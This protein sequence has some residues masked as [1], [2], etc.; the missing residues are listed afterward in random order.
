MEYTVAQI[1]PVKTQVNV[2]VPAEEATAALSTA[3]ALFR[4]KADIKGFRKGKVPSS[5]VEQR[6]K[7]E[8]VSEATTDLINVHINDIMGELKLAPLAGLDVSEAALAKG[9]PLAY[10][11]TFEHAPAFELPEYKGQAIEEEDVIVSDADI[12]A[13]IERVRKN[14]AEV[15]PISDNRTPVD[16]D[17]V[18]V[19]F[20]AFENGVAVPG[21]RAENFE[22][23]LG[24][25][26]SLADFEALV[27]TVPAGSEG[28]GE[29]TFPADFINTDLAGRTVTMKVAVHVIK[30]R[31]LPPV[32]DE[33]A[34]KAGNFEGLD[35]M[36]EAITMSYKKSREDL[37][38]SSAQKKL[39]DKL[40]A[41]LDF[42]LPPTAVEQ[43]L[44]QMVQEFVGQL[45]R[46]GK[47]LE[48]TGKSLAEIEG[49]LRSQAEEL[50]KTQIYLSA[51]A[52]KEELTVTPQEM[53]A[54]FYRLST[55]VGQDVI[56][57]KRYYE[58]N[59][60]MIMVRDKLL[61][62]KAADLI[63]ASAL[64]TKVAPTEAAAEATV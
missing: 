8:I 6:F 17:V 26:Q 51:V 64:V 59:G 49:E 12:D 16:G 44:G 48:S 36:R 22:M 23:T 45:E 62:D 13:V 60:M 39:L 7:K 3:V 61:A 19:T 58:D 14:L 41:A 27:K 29:M 54:F 20:E 43:Q 46:R 2:S 32:D 53:D 55:Q 47:S 31:T 10:T 18:S 1:S 34:K 57:L 5:V 38:R 11:F 40:L 33:L 15:A 30:V 56:L 4:S 42:P 24:E 25:G 37:H 21:V 9:E 52:A 35:K 28:E 50:V 63:Y